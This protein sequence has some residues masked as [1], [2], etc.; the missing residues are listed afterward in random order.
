MKVPVSLR[1]LSY[2]RRIINIF[3]FTSLL[4][5]I[6]VRSLSPVMDSIE[7]EFGSAKNIPIAT[8]KEYLEMIIQAMEK[9]NSNLSWH[10]FFKL[11]PQI[12][13]KGIET[14]GFNSARAPPRLTVLT[15]VSS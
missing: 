10:V 11:N 6:F 5:Y 13:S 2:I 7:F 9:F 1:T 12:T 8:K 4:S 15:I 3:I 14:F